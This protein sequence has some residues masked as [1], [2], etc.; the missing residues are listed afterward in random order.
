MADK[1]EGA[2][3][4]K[5]NG[6]IKLHYPML[7]KLNYL[8]WA[9]KMPMNQQEQGV[10]GSIQNKC[11]EKRKDRIALTTIYQEILEDVLLTLAEMDIAK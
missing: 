7:M 8:V 4:S 6:I 1:G 2:Q 9:I 3:K 10:R 5:K 11:V